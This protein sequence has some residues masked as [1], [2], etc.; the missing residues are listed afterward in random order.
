MHPSQ[1]AAQSVPVPPTDRPA[2]ETPHLRMAIRLM[3]RQ[4]LSWWLLLAVLVGLATWASLA[5]VSGFLQVVVWLG[6]SL[7]AAVVADLLLMLEGWTRATGRLLP[8]STWRPATAELEQ[9]GRNSLMMTVTEKDGDAFRLR[10]LGMPTLHREVIARTRNVW[11]VG[12]DRNGWA[13]LVTP[14]LHSPLGGRLEK[15]KSRPAHPVLPEAPITGPD[16]PAADDFVVASQA[17][18]KA[19]AAGRGYASAGAVVALGVVA[20]VVALL[21]GEP[22][23]GAAVLVACVAG[24]VPLFLSARALAVWKPLPELLAAGTWTRLP[25]TFDEGW[26]PNS[27]GHA[28]AEAAVRLPS[29]ETVAVKLPQVSCDIVEYTRATGTMWFAGMPQPGSASAVGVPGYPLVDVARL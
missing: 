15:G 24:A 20:L 29:G 13:V 19:G 3:K 22:L 8:N 9:A 18:N 10:T 4:L 5:D 11:V 7:F 21:L 6:V 25:A 16:A 23:V 1:A 28:D 14:G 12:P 26:R 17:K 27:R 2:A